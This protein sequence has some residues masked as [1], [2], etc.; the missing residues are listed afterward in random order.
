MDQRIAF[1]IRALMKEESFLQLCREFGIS[2]KTGYKWR[3]RFLE[4]GQAGL[5]DESRRPRSSAKT[6]E[7]IVCELV[8]I[9]KLKARWGPKKI[10][11]LYEASHPGEQIP[12]LSTVSRILE[13]SGFV[14]K[15]KRRRKAANVETHSESNSSFEVE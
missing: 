10:R 9:K 5:L 4:K 12:S 13:K 1:V 6:A 2:T 14:D 7:D 3:D 8:R 15:K 11:N